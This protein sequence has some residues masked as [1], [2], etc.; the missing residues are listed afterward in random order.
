M[1]LFCRHFIG[2]YALYLLMIV[3]LEKPRVV[4]CHDIAEADSLLAF[5]HPE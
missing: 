1:R 5:E 4:T 3:V 2:S